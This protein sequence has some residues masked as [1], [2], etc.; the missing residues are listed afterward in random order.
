MAKI[1]G[2]QKL[3]HI[4]MGHHLQD[5]EKGPIFSSK[6][7]VMALH[8]ADWLFKHRFFIYLS[9]LGVSDLLD[10]MKNFFLFSHLS[11]IAPELGYLAKMY[12]LHYLIA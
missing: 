12:L 9:Y 6:K 4:H 1:S 10:V 3:T 2:L 8:S 5:G 7:I 11:V